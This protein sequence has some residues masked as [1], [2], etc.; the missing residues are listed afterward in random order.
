MEACVKNNVERLIYSSSA[1]VYGDTE[2]PM[3]EDHPFNNKISMAQQRLLA[4][5]RCSF[6]HRYGLPYVGLRYMNV[7]APD[8]IIKGLI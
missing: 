4:K 2:E 6:H 1:S 5:Q 8:K 3:T 7:Y